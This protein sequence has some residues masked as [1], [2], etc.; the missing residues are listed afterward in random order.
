M[1][2]RKPHYSLAAIQLITADPANRV[3]T[4]TAL[5]GGLAMGLMESE[6][7]E[8]VCALTPGGLFKSMTAIRDH[9]VWQDVYHAMTPVG[10]MAYIKITGYKDGRPPVIQFKRLEDER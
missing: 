10:V 6:M 9:K 1:E 2:K 8:V 4:A 7:R 5:E 3:F